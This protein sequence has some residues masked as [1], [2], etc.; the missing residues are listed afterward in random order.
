MLPT[1]TGLTV[2][3]SLFPFIE[4][5]TGLLIISNVNIK[6]SIRIA[7]CISLVMICFIIADQLYSRLIYHGVIIGLLVF[8]CFKVDKNQQTPTL[9]V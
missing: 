6:K 5:F 1:E 3:A 2:G 4:F 7:F 9:S 8:L